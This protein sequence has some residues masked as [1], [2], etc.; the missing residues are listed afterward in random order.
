MRISKLKDSYT[1]TSCKRLKGLGW[2]GRYTFGCKGVV[3]FVAI[4]NGSCS[5]VEVISVAHDVEL[6][7][8]P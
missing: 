2:L 6:C 3:L 4:G 7:R 1:R 8:Y 5:K